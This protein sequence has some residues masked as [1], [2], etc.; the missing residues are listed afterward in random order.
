LRAD[1]T[2]LPYTTY[3]RLP[4]VDQGAI[5]ENKRLGHVLQ[6]A[7]LVQEQRDSRRSRSVPSRANQGQGAIQMKPAPGKKA[8]RKL[9][10]RDLA[11]AIAHTQSTKVIAPGK[12]RGL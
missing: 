3:D 9:D 6:I 5:V 12:K 2:A 8:Q 10:E 11:A 4:Q 7:R 1:G